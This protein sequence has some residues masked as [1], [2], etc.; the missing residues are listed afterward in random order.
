MM[1]FVFGMQINI[2]VFCKLILSF[3]VRVTRYAQSTQ[4]KFAYLSISTEKHGGRVK[5]I[6]C[7]QINS[8]TFYKLIVSLWVCIAR[9]AQS[10][11]NNFT[12]SLQYL[13]ENMKDEVD[14]LP[15]NKRQ[16]FLQSYTTILDVCGQACPNYPT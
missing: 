10:T 16:R 13:K 9:H 4:N 11:Q 14:F 3:W 1:N 8:K 5:L 6:F 7:L 2:K 12:I 15:A